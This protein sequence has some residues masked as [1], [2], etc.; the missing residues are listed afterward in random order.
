MIVRLCAKLG[1]AR[2]DEFVI[3]LSPEEIESTYTHVAM[4]REPKELLA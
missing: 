4:V 2:V 1:F 3:K